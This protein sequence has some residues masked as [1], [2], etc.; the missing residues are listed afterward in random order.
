[1]DPLWALLT[2]LAELCLYP[3]PS[4]RWQQR[5]AKVYNC[6]KVFG[7]WMSFLLMKVQNTF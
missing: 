3:N 1:M 6:N 7:T 2:V 4:T 5:T